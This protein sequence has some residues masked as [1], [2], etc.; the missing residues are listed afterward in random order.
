MRI[1]LDRTMCDGFGACAKHAP[2]YFSLDDW[3]YASLEGNGTIPDKDRDDAVPEQRDDVKHVIDTGLPPG[4]SP[5][6][7]S[8]PGAKTPGSTPDFV[9]GK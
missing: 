4:I 8:D 1:R 6:Q 3:G 5:D 2:E 9:R 7:A